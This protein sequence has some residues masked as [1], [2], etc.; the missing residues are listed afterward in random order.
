MVSLDWRA[1]YLVLRVNSFIAMDLV[2]ESLL[3]I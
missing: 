1:G 2:E 3:W